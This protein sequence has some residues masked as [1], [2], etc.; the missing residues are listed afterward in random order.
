MRLIKRITVL[1][2]VIISSNAQVPDL[3]IKIFLSHIFTIL[4]LLRNID[5]NAVVS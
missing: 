5:F 3:K 1:K 4:G 2:L